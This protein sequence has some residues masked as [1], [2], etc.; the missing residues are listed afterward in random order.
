MPLLGLPQRH[1]VDPGA[2][3]ASPLQTARVFG[4]SRNQRSASSESGVRLGP[5]SRQCGIDVGRS[6]GRA[7][8]I[9]LG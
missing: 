3:R 6:A 7:S 4:I 1:R 2:S 8:G 5:K 9:N